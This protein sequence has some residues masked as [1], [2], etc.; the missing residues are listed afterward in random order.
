MSR[1]IYNKIGRNSFY[2]ILR[3]VLL[4]PFN[5][6]LIPI[7]LR[8][9]G[10]EGYGV[11]VFVQTVMTFA[12][13]MDFGI[14]S[15]ITK[16]TA[17]Y[18]AESNYTKILQ[19][20]N[21]FFVIYLCIS[22]VF[23]TV[24]LLC[25][26]W[27]ITTFIKTDVIAGGDI[28]FVLLLSAAIFG[29]NIAFSVY[30]SFL[31]GLQRMDLTNKAGILWGVCNF[32]FSVVF[33]YLGW[34]I[35]GLVIANGLS[36]LIT[37]F[38][39]ILLTIKVA[40]YLKLNPFLFD[41]KTL[42][43]VFRFSSY[44]AIGGILAMLHFKFDKLIISYFLGLEYLTFYDVAHKIVFLI[45]GISGSFTTS[46]MPAA[47]STYVNLGLSKMKE[48]F[49]ATFKYSALI[50]I[51]VFLFISVMSGQIIFLWLGPGYENSAFLLRFLSIAYLINV[52]TGP[53]AAILTGMGL[54]RIPFLGSLI[55]ATTSVTLSVILIMK[56]GLPAVIISPLVA[57]TLGAIY[58]FVMLQKVLDVS[59]LGLFYQKLKL[60][61]LSGVGIIFCIALLRQYLANGFGTLLITAL[62]YFA[63]Y[64]ASI[65]I[66][67]N[68]EYKV[69]RRIIH[70]PLV[71]M[72]KAYK[73]ILKG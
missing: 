11:W 12:T 54:P 60:P 31:N 52:L 40:P 25:Q 43:R 38:T 50:A 19:V 65:Y 4:L 51:P 66:N 5:L 14:S 13:L 27:I 42:S 61:I 9:I 22:V 68:H 44:G 71:T 15:G 37:M 35:K 18:E 63:L 20:F 17:Q 73:I 8:Y 64:T 7:I 48:I 41:F 3:R 10:V 58:G 34:G 33:L 56:I 32:I 36:S 53:G 46:I 2:N 6:I 28:S 21:T 55:T 45:W 59:V 67:G 69:V 1:E 39:H 57:H 49:Q 47:S 23:F 30:P 24:I 70:E 72:E 29:M 16:F 62:L 26:D